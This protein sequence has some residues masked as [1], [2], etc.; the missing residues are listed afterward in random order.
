MGKAMLGARVRTGKATTIAT[1]GPIRRLLQ[2]IKVLNLA[3][4]MVLF[5]VQYTLVKARLYLYFEYP[6]DCE[7]L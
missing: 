5:V 4:F 3:P 6:G 7:K 1:H 2:L